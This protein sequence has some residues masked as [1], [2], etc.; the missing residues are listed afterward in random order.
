M[1]WELVFKI[2]LFCVFIYVLD[3]FGLT[4]VMCMVLGFLWMRASEDIKIMHILSEEYREKIETLE[5][6]NEKL[7]KKIDKNK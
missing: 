3:M 2:L 6:L 1:N 4:W 5:S 7:L